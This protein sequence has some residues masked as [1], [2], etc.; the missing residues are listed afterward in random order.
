MKKTTSNLRLWQTCCSVLRIF[1]AGFT[2]E[3][4]SATKFSDI[5]LNKSFEFAQVEVAQPSSKYSAT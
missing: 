3:S 2:L 4:G 1:G 5:L